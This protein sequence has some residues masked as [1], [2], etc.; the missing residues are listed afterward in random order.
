[1]SFRRCLAVFGI[2][3]TY[4]MASEAEARNFKDETF[5]AID[6]IVELPGGR[7]LL[8]GNYTFRVVEAAAGRYIVQVLTADDDSVLTTILAVEPGQAMIVVGETPASVPQPVRYWYRPRGT[9]G[10]VGYEFV[11]PR[12]QAMRIARMTNRYVLT[13][14][15]AMNNRDAMMQAEVRAIEPQTSAVAY[16]EPASSRAPQRFSPL[17]VISVAVLAVGV[18]G[19]RFHRHITA[20]G[21]WRH[22]YDAD[23]TV[24]R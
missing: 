20:A 21:D 7:T 3:L 9:V 19:L 1:M 5:V 14:D 24:P 23:T 15:S 16:R 13:T 6:R 11:Y 10:P 17:T 2:V 22:R 4:A 8:P 18:V 12:A